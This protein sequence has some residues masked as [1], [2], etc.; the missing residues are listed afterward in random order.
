MAYVGACT[1]GGG[2]GS[3]T[4][5]T[6]T[7]PAG[8]AAGQWVVIASA[9]N[10]G[11]ATASIAGQSPISG[12]VTTGSSIRIYLWAF[13][14]TAGHIT[15]GTITV[16]W[17]ASLRVTASGAVFS[18][19][20]GVDVDSAGTIAAASSVGV[21]SVTT[22]VDGCTLV[23]AGLTRVAGTAA[24][25]TFPSGTEVGLVST[26][27]A[28]GANTAAELAYQTTGAAGAYG[29]GT[30]T[31]SPAA[32]HTGTFTLALK[33]ASSDFSGTATL[34]GSGALSAAGTPVAAGTAT[35]SG[36]G[37][38]TASSQPAAAADTGLSGSGT[39]AASGTAGGED[40]SSTPTLSGSGSLSAAGYAGTSSSPTLTGTGLLATSA[41]PSLTRSVALTGAGTLSAA[42]AA[43]VHATAT[44]SGSGTLAASGNASVAHVIA[45]S[46]TGGLAPTS[47]PAW[48]ASATLTGLGTLEASGT[49]GQAWIDV[50][51][52]SLG[53]GLR[54]VTVTAASGSVTVSAAVRPLGT[55]AATAPTSIAATTGAVTITGR[56]T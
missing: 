32:A 20:D 11:S 29:A 37:G 10:T 9:A 13:A 12:P 27:A 18:E 55:T 45:L 38:L 24:S 5:R 53:A 43:A 56:T 39:L 15:A 25:P 31:T 48:I 1:G 42:A 3:A 44:L 36:S 23:V 52:L 8:S 2:S 7:L 50:T 17:T 35:L 49:T 21:Q 34:S 19:V 4:T 30:I 46:G 41:R 6:L 47:S 28:S 26:T 54:A 51:W 22:T 14:L 33:P 40:Y 16:T